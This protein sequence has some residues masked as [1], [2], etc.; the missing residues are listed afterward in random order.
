MKRRKTC[1]NLLRFLLDCLF[2]NLY[3]K[4]ELLNLVDDAI[5]V[6]KRSDFDLEADFLLV[7]RDRLKRE[8]LSSW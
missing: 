5:V 1:L 7:L 2:S 8:V 4:K 3:D 6:L